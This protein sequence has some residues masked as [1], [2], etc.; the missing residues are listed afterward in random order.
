VI[1]GRWLTDMPVADLLGRVMRDSAPARHT[2]VTLLLADRNGD[3]PPIDETEIPVFYRLVRGMESGRVCDLLA[4][5]SSE[6]PPVP[7][8]RPAPALAEVVDA[9]ASAIGAHTEPEDAARA[10]VAAVIELL[11]ATRAHCLY[12]DEESS[13]IWPGAAEDATG[14]DKTEASASIGIAGFAMRAV[15]GIVVPRAAEDAMYRAAVDD[16]G[17]TGGERLAVHPVVGP[18]GHVHAVLIAVREATRPPFS[19][20]DLGKLEALA[21]AWGPYVL[22]LAMRTEA[23]QILGD[24]LDRG[25]SDLFRQEAIVNLVQRGQHGDVIRVHPAWIRAAYW[26]VLASLTVAVAYAALAQVPNYAQG[27]GVV[28][29]AGRN[30]VIAHAAG[31]VASLDAASGQRVERDQV[32]ARLYDA[33]EVGQLAAL[34]AELEGK[35]VTY[36]QTPADPAAK[37]ALGEARS[38]RD[39]ARLRVESHTIRAPYAGIVREVFVRGGQRV[40]AGSAVLS[41]GDRAGDEELTVTAFLP[42]SERPRLRTHQQLRIKLAGYRGDHIT[43]EVRAVSDVLGAAEARARF[44]GERFADSLPA[45]GTVVVVEATLA[46]S[47]FEADGQMFHLHGGMMG[48]VEVRLES[49]SLLRRLIPGLR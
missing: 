12:C 33:E 34:D 22:Q 16:P 15:A 41:L 3:T 26:L 11:G 46:S 5:A 31:T 7:P 43:A 18:D 37:Q 38:A 8:G 2:P 39:R 6:L 24:R 25:P 29:I 23:D 9:H 49:R 36:L 14:A 30:E 13:A 21:L 48:V 10:A 4:K 40:E 28:R 35:L 32:L 45:T 42:G 44:L 1:A 19:A 47:A 20:D 17:G 27:V